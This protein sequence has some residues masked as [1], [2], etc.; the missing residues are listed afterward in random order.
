MDNFLLNVDILDKYM[1]LDVRKN[2]YF[3]CEKDSYS[4]SPA[5][6]G[7]LLFKKDNIYKLFREYFPATPCINTEI[8][9]IDI[10]NIGYFAQCYNLILHNRA[11]FREKR[12]DSILNNI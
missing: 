6:V 10:Y 1:C 4:I 2:E 7:K 8:G 9:K 11:E 5:T 12:I 3:L